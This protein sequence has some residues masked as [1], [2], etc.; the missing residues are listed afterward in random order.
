MDE[1]ASFI[2]EWQSGEGSFAA[3][4]KSFGISRTLGY[5]YVLRYV[6]WG[7]AGLR[8]QP[9]APRRVW[10][11]T[12]PKIEKAIVRMRGKWPRIGPLKILQVLKERYGARRKLPAVSTIALVL[13]RHGLVK[14]RR[15]IR[16]IRAVHPIFEAQAPQ[17]DLER[18]LQR[19]VPHG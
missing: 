7:A 3:L 12:D 4:C 14:K 15:R 9:R 1:K 17:R 2:L 13:K 8:E 11:R 18:G 19:Q 5:R 10:N 16:R 6:L